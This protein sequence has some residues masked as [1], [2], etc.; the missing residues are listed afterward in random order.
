MQMGAFHGF[1]F[2]PSTPTQ[3]TLGQLTM[4]GVSQLLHTA[5]ILHQA[6]GSALKLS[7]FTNA[8]VVVYCT[9]YRRTFQSVLALLFPL[10]PLELFSRVVIRE[11]PSMRFCFSDCAC[12]SAEHFMR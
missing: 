1:P 8:D 7:N 6:Y 11:S 9:R 10:L 2:L 12:S 4:Q 5:Q 3:C